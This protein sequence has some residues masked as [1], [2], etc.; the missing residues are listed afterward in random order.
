MSLCVYVC[1]CPLPPTPLGHGCRRVHV[2]MHGCSFLFIFPWS[3]FHFV[4]PHSSNPPHH[5][6]TR[7]I[8]LFFMQSLSSRLIEYFHCNC[9]LSYAC[10]LY[11]FRLDHSLSLEYSFFLI[12]SISLPLCLHPPPTSSHPHDRKLESRDIVELDARMLAAEYADVPAA[13]KAEDAQLRV[14]LRNSEHNL[15]LE[16]HRESARVREN[17]VRVMSATKDIGVPELALAHMRRNA[18]KLSAQLSNRFAEL[19]RHKLGK[20]VQSRSH[21]NPS[22]FTTHTV[23]EAGTTKICINCGVPNHTIRGSRTFV[24][25]SC[26]WVGERDTDSGLQI[27]RADAVIRAAAYD[28]IHA[29]QDAFQTQLQH[30]VRLNGGTG[31]A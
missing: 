13:T 6:Y 2:H 3:P 29:H 1:V 25:K 7:S 17:V 22:Q 21:A 14:A 24:C 27:L 31:V 18:N 15:L 10:V 4:I 23:L 11:V 20:L 9:W 8:V 5:V 30:H 12:L 19:G 16:Q 26:G 28:Y